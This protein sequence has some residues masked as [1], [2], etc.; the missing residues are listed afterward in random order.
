MAIKSTMTEDETKLP[1]FK[2]PP[3][4]ETVLAIQFDPIENLGA[5]HCADYRA[6]IA[7]RYPH[8]EEKAPLPRTSESFDQEN[9]PPQPNVVFQSGMPPLRRCWFLDSEGNGIVQLD[10]EHFAH[11]WRN[12]TGNAVYPRYEYV[13]DEFQKLW[14]GFL[15]FLNEADLGRPKANHW[16]VTYVN[17]I[18]VGEGWQSLSEL[19]N[20]LTVWPRLPSA[21]ALSAPE[22]VQATLVYSIPKEKRRLRVSMQSA[23]RRSDM[24]ECILLKLIARGR[25]GSPEA[26]EVLKHLDIGRKWIVQTFADLTSEE[27][28][29]RWGREG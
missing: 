4:S 29:E 15:E 5:I 16:E 25:V 8:F 24:Q 20:A 19:H 12:N 17:H 10:A 13:R 28:H 22:G 7:A 3:V 6:R 1:S 9:S 18:D 27:A 23:I 21:G 26:D 2:A 11:N 14:I